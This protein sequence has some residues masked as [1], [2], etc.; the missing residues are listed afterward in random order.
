[1]EQ[2]IEKIT[3]FN[4][5]LRRLDSLNRLIDDCNSYSRM[6]Y[7]NGYNIEYL[8]LWR[9]TLKAIFREVYPK[10]N[11]EEKKVVNTLWKKAIKIGKIFEVKKTREGK[12][13]ILNSVKFK[14]HWNLL[15]KIDADLRVLADD[16]GMLM[17]N[18]DTGMDAISEM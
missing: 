10:L 1:M 9:N 7:L 3:E 12:I 16:K 18:K 15:N 17:T 4:S 11:K 8:K 2:S 13:K 5:S 14:R 6:S